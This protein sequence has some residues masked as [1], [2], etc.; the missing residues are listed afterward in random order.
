MRRHEECA[1]AARS[2]VPLC[3]CAHT[4][5][6]RL[7]AKAGIGKCERSRNRTRGSGRLASLQAPARKKGRR[8]HKRCSVRSTAEVHRSP[9]VFAAQRDSLRVR[10]L[11]LRPEGLDRSKAGCESSRRRHGDRKAVGL[12]CSAYA[13]HVTPPLPT[14]RLMWSWKLPHETKHRLCSRYR[15]LPPGALSRHRVCGPCGMRPPLACALLFHRAP[16]STWAACIT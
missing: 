12:A 4:R 7:A 8:S 13:L 16:L 6:L 2:A 9:G 11:N 5:P 3:F 15:A 1:R 14:G 10:R